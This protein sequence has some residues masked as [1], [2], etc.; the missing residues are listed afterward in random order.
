[1]K[2]MNKE[3]IITHIWTCVCIIFVTYYVC[4]FLFNTIKVYKLSNGTTIS[5]DG[6]GLV[7]LGIIIAVY[8]I[9]KIL[10]KKD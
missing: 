4:Q 9:T 10:I 6:A 1:M 7:E 2:K 5:F 3:K 8:Y